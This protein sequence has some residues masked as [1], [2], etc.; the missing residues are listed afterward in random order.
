[1]TITPYNQWFDSTELDLI[2]VT[3]HN[4]GQC[5]GIDV[6]VFGIGLCITID[7]SDRPDGYV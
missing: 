5:A 7:I 2:M 6:C 1:M 4:C 3:I